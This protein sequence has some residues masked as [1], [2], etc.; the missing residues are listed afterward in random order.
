M[1]RERVLAY[2]GAPR[3]FHSDNGW[4]FVNQLMR[5]LLELW[6]RDV[7]LVN[8]RPRHSQS[9]GLVER[10]NREVEKNCFHEGR[11]GSGRLLLQR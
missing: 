2:V 6:N 3:I 7:T 4:E 10:G 9:Q 5:G 1:F 8:G 11:P